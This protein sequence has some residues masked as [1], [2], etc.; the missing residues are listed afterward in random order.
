MIG[1]WCL[2]GLMED[3]YHQGVF[4]VLCLKAE[5]AEVYCVVAITTVCEIQ[6]GLLFLS[7]V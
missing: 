2:I 3:A 6:L 7:K 5:E 4:P 1:H